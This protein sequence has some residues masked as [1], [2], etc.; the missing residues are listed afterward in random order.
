MMNSQCGRM[1]A[2]HDTDIKQR[3]KAVSFAL[4]ETVLYL[5]AYPDSKD[6]LCQY[7]KLIEELEGVTDEYER[8]YG[9]LTIYSN[10][11]DRWDWIHSPWPWESE[12]N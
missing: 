8:K 1:S 6:A 2:C 5:D 12:A 4:Y 9:P 7:N 3:L 11:G 10:T